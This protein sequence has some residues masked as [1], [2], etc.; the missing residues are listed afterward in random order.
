LLLLSLQIRAGYVALS[1]EAQLDICRRGYQSR[2][3][4]SQLTKKIK[5]GKMVVIWGLDLREMQWGKFKGSYMFSKVYH[6]QRTKM[7]VYQIAMI[8]CVVSE[9]VGTAALSGTL[10]L[11][12]PPKITY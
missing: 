11:P 12:F 3:C 8:L 10:N 9:S 6:L 7:I 4:I 1:F 5:D 2:I